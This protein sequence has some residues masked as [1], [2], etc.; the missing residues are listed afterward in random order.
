[1]K[2]QKFFQLVLTNKYGG[3]NPHPWAAALS[4]ILSL[5]RHKKRQK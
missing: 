4:P 1:M 5:L 3:F 2:N